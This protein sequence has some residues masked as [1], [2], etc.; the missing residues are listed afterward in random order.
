MKDSQGDAR[1][2]SNLVGGK[3]HLKP[4]PLSKL[5]AFM[6][7]TWS[8]RSIVLYFALVDLLRSIHYGQASNLSAP[9]I[10]SVVSSQRQKAQPGDDPRQL[11]NDPENALVELVG[12][13][14]R[15]HTVA[16]VFNPLFRIPTAS[17]PETHGWKPC[18]YIPFS[19]TMELAEMTGR[20]RDNL[21][22]WQR[23]YLA[24][25]KAEVVLLWHLCQIYLSLPSLQSL[26]ELSGYPPR[27]IAAT[28][29]VDGALSDMTASMDL[30]TRDLEHGKDA[31]E[32]AWKILDLSSHCKGSVATM[33]WKPLALFCA[34][35][36]VWGSLSIQKDGGGPA[37]LNV[38]RLFGAEIAKMEIP[39]TREMFEVLGRSQRGMLGGRPGG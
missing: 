8:I 12:I 10:L 32:H 29:D 4:V 11:Q 17:A 7:L 38:L 36:S 39:C 5:S 28:S 15:V 13:L 6:W 27:A 25:A 30:V 19:G 21:D 31:L 9:E 2:N 35:L 20:L 1:T 23:T 16:V 37:S 26:I 14:S 22:T 18:D 3:N 24:T 34:A 33:I